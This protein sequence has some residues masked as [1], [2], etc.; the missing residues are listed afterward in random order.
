VWLVL[1][2]RR[3]REG[4]W[5]ALVKLAMVLLFASLAGWLAFTMVA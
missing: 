4:C 1:P 5:A 3:G 2:L